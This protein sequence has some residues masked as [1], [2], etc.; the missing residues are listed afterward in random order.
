[1]HSENFC[2]TADGP[3]TGHLKGRPDFVPVVHDL[4]CANLNIN[5]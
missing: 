5:Y 1:M 2:R 4:S 3:D